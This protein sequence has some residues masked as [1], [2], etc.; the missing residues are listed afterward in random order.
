MNEWLSWL[1]NKSGFTNSKILKI[2]KGSPNIP[3]SLKFLEQGVHELVR[4]LLNPLPLN[5]FV[6]S[7]R[8]SQEG[9]RTIILVV[10]LVVTTLY[11]MTS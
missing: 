7:K 3:P 2:V 9:L 11:L 1:P 5:N 4:G 6:V 8:L 10:V